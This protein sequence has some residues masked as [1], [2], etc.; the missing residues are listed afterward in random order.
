MADMGPSGDLGAPPALPSL[1]PGELATFGAS[2]DTIDAAKQ[3]LDRIKSRHPIG[4]SEVGASSAEHIREDIAQV[5]ALA[6]GMLESDLKKASAHATLTERFPTMQYCVRRQF[7]QWF[8]D[9]HGGKIRGRVPLDYWSKAGA[10]PSNTYHPSLSWHYDGALKDTLIRHDNDVDAAAAE[11]DDT[12][13]A[14][15]E[16]EA[17]VQEQLSATLA[18]CAVEEPEHD[19]VA[20]RDFVESTLASTGMTVVRIQAVKLAPVNSGGG[21][22]GGGGGNTTRLF[23]GTSAVCVDSI[24]REGLR[25][26]VVTPTSDLDMG[27]I[28]CGALGK[29]VYFSTSARTAAW[30]CGGVHQK[31][32][33]VLLCDV[34]LGN[35]LVM[36][37]YAPTLCQGRAGALP[38]GDV[39]LDGLEKQLRSS[40]VGSVRVPPSDQPHSLPDDEVAVYDPK[41]CKVTHVVT[42]DISG[43]VS[44]M[45][46]MSQ[47]FQERSRIWGGGGCGGAGVPERPAGYQDLAMDLWRAML[48]DGMG[49]G[50]ALTTLVNLQLPP[51][52]PRRH[53]IE[54]SHIMQAAGSLEA[55]FPPLEQPS[56]PS[57]PS[58][59]SPTPSARLQP[60]TTV[61][62]STPT[63]HPDFTFA[64]PSKVHTRMAPE[65]QI[66]QVTQMVVPSH[67]TS[68]ARGDTS[69]SHSCLVEV[70]PDTVSTAQPLATF[71][72]Q[73]QSFLTIIPCCER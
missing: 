22:G 69:E 30:F 36:H 51:G 29:A 13:Q 61:P 62:P 54:H 12:L 27:D 65:V 4:S 57:S 58:P 24:V 1:R 47:I 56:P 25:V 48:E 73:C 16:A 55:C 67:W 53:N 59:P 42:L 15:R 26:P 50:V 3:L 52:D 35:E 11:L 18:E 64:K 63:I 7:N 71:V 38:T 37:E 2:Q 17:A 28:S 9:Y 14:R 44:E 70:E 66:A 45:A 21:G 49:V 20:T 32:V 19:A 46:E 31:H 5:S 33:T 72:T 68:A 23:H 34:D 43:A 41:R 40:T 60:T 10:D 8:A 39:D 6:L